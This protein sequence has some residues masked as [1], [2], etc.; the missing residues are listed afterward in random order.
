MS[1]PIESAASLAIGT[2]ESVSPSEIK[3]IL[4]ID[5]PQATAL[6]TGVPTR[7]PRINGYVLIPNESG[8]LVGLVTWL[9][10]ERSSFPKRTGLKDFGLVD[11]PFPLRKMSVSPLG[12]LQ[13]EYDTCSCS[14]V[15]RLERG[16]STFP[17][18]GD[19][20]H[21]PTETQLKSIIE[22]QGPDRRVQIGTSPLSA[23][24]K[25]FIDPNKLFGRHVAVLGNTGSGKSCTVAGLIRWSLE[26]AE[27][28]IE[29][30]EDA[31]DDQNVN[32]RFIILDPNGEYSDTFSDIGEG[33]RI[34]RVP[35]VEDPINTLC[36]PAW[37]WNSNEWIAFAGAAP[38]AQQPLLLKALREMRSGR[39]ITDSLERRLSR[40]YKARLTQI[41]AIVNQG[42]IAYTDWRPAGF[43]GRT[44]KAMVEEARA[45]A[46][47]ASDFSDQ[48]EDLADVADEVAEAS[49]WVSQNG[50]SDGYDPFNEVGLNRV[51]KSLET[52]VQDL[53]DSPDLT[54]RSEDAPISFEVQELPDQLDIIAEGQ[55]AQFVQWLN[56]RIRTI[57]TDGKLKQI[58]APEE[59]PS[60]VEWLTDYIGD[61]E[62]ENG[63]IAIIDLSLVPTDVLH[64]VIAAASRIVFEAAQRFRK[65]NGTELPT[66]LVLEEAHTFISRPDRK[67]ADTTNA[68][69]MCRR[70]FERIAREGRK[71]G[72]GLV[73]SS[74]RPSELSATVLAQCNTF[75]LHRIVNDRDQQLV[76]R[77]VP[78]NLAGLLS[79]LP[80][81][82][83]R[84]AI[85]LGW[86]VPVP[87][88]VEINELP[89]HHCPTSQD[90][91]FW[92]V[93]TGEEKRPID[94]DEIV[95]D[96]IS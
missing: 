56:M 47:E 41:R 65:V 94:W 79:D 48:L 88:L 20:V 21:L 76:N 11:L 78:D 44:L 18:V 29:E 96:W 62:A 91:S 93:W 16:V 83:T 81:L 61:N 69:V 86:V 53:P 45:H 36:L 75:I 73:L 87:V 7:F 26:Q 35:P 67:D 80:S 12:S 74:Q 42:P 64:V 27:K 17:S 68:A 22:A 49:H 10:V 46:Q 84:R 43:C 33:V 95:E 71:F 34:F 4:E 60:L 8:A 58:V 57:V 31:E 30:S 6:N 59:Q 85:L 89:R 82:P 50:S 14:E 77:L 70:T 37:M 24:A 52:V 66:V 51:V 2:V 92:E 3:V 23:G 38:G 25:V 13:Q 39:E 1:T 54:F 28:V 19:A 55:A 90:P 15:L 32:A 5:A 40:I 9:G 72:V 63:Q